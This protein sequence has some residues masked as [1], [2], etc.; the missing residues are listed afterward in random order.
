MATLKRVSPGDLIKAEIWSDMIDELIALDARVAALE[1]IEPI[2]EPMKP[3]LTGRSPTGDI[4][5]PSRLTVFGRNFINPPNGQ[6]TLSIAGLDF[7]QFVPGSNDTQLMV[8]LPDFGGSPPSSAQVVVSNRNGSSNPLPVQMHAVVQVPTGITDVTKV[9]QNLATIEVG[10]KYTF[11]FQVA[12]TL[13]HG[14]ETYEVAAAYMNAQ[15]ASASAWNSATRLVDESGTTIPSSRVLVNTGNPAKVGVEVTVPNGATSVELAVHA[16][17]LHNDAQLSTTSPLITVVV[18]QPYTDNPNAPTFILNSYPTGPAV[19]IR[20]KTIGG[21][22]VVQVSF[23]KSAQIS[24]DVGLRLAGTY[25]FSAS[26]DN[27]GTLWALDPVASPI[28]PPGATVV[29]PQS[30]RVVIGV[31]NTATSVVSDLHDLAL[32]ASKL[33]GAGGNVEFSTQ[34]RFPIGVFDM[35]NPQ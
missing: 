11:V 4:A 8:D 16:E 2:P 32:T 5:V 10:K 31:K 17:S 23:G 18:G 15:G 20:K 35:S 7:T 28:D 27:P 19:P 12:A 24:V 6:N 29:S 30:Q 22:D 13:A 14:P 33:T 25:T 26:I 3:Q 9:T 21:V 1:A 34:F